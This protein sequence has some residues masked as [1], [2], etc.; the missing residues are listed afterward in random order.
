MSAETKTAP[1]V[2]PHAAELPLSLYLELTIHDPDT[3]AELWSHPEG[4]PR[5]QFALQA[6]RIGVLALK[7][8]RGQIDAD[9]VRRESERLLETLES[10]LSQHSQFVH[11]RV[12]TVLKEYFDPASGRFQ[13]RVQRLISKDGELEQLLRRQIGSEDSELCKTLASHIGRD[14][15]LMKVLSPEESDGLLAAFREALEKQL[16]EQREQVL[17][18]F[19]LDNK[20]GAL[21][22]FINELQERQ[23]ELSKNLHEKIDEVVK[24]FS[25][26]EENSALNRLVR[27]VDRAQKTITSE[28]SLDEEGSAL[29]RLKRMLEETNE[30]IDKHLSLDDDE[31]A[32]ARLKRELLNILKEH[33]QTQQKFQSEVRETLQEMKVRK[34]EAERSTRHGLEFEEAVVRQIQQEAQR[35]AD[36][37]THTG[38]TTGSIRHC[39]VGDCVVELGPDSAAPGATFVIEA[40]EQGGYQLSEARQEIETAR[41]N[42]GAQVGL[43]VFSKRTAPEGTEPLCRLGTDVFVVWDAEDPASD[44]FLRTAYTLARALCVR[45]Q[46][47]TAAQTADFT[48]IE[49]AILEIEKRAAA[50]DDV[51]TWTNTIQNNSEKILKKLRTTRKSLERQVETL[52]EKTQD[53]RTTLGAEG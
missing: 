8:A 45:T 33:H 16:L 17:A 32:L 48:A 23:G 46:E 49:E 13:E 28:F 11:D 3:I 10:R 47:Q 25:L 18:Q 31:S 4:G 21:C 26:D 15:P 36:V 30:T 35:S 27:N 50:L 37:A 41:K 9:L 42:R 29:S 43:F 44:L 1:V 40:K 52:R 20:Q 22:R 34:A 7:Q 38:H 14:S 2:E 24:E 12:T 6:L 39:K 5:E 53:L 51:E 19:S